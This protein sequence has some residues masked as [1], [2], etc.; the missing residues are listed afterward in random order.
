MTY[1]FIAYIIFC[2]SLLWCAWLSVIRIHKVSDFRGKLI[3]ELFD[4]TDWE[5]QKQLFE[6]VSFDTMVYKFWKPLTVESFWWKNTK[7]L[8]NIYQYYTWKWDDKVN[9][10]KKDGEYISKV[11]APVANDRWS[12]MSFGTIIWDNNTVNNNFVVNT[13]DALAIIGSI[14]SEFQPKTLQ[15]SFDRVILRFEKTSVNPELS[16][17]WVIAEI[18]P[19]NLKVTF[20]D[21]EVKK[22]IT[23]WERNIFM[24]EYLVDVDVKYNG[25]VP[26]W[27]I[28]KNIRDENPLSE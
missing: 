20:D 5:Y 10:D 27:Y 28:I 9:I 21:Q 19:R 17:R 12:N 7:F 14:G 4:R 13:P 15:K 16:D 6:Q 23:T 26:H 11:F 1:I 22:K 2:F 25:D 18:Y 3:D 24:T 8:K